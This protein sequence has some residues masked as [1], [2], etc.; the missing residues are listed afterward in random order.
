MIGSTRQVGAFA[1][2]GPALRRV[3]MSWYPAVGETSCL[4]VRTPAGS[5]R[6][7]ASQ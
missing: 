3:S 7:E 1:Y 4:A 5:R 6:V 2:G